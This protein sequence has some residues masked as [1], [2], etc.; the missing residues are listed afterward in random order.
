[1]NGYSNGYTDGNAGQSNGNNGHANGNGAR[2]SNAPGGPERDRG[3]SSLRIAV[4]SPPMLPVPPATYAGTERVVA[5]LVDELHARGHRVTLFAP[6]DSETVAELV[7]TIDR[8]LWSRGYKG[9]VSSYINVTLARISGHAGRFDIIHSHV[10]TLGFLFAR[11]CPTPVVTTLHGR[12]DH[13][14]MPELLDEFRDIPLV[15]ISDSQRRWFPQANWMGTIHHGLPLERLPFSD[16]PGSYLAFVGRVTPEKGVAD[17]IELARRTRLPLRMAAKVYDP[18]EHEYFADVV[19]PAIREG[20]VTFLG[21]LGPTER[22]ALYAG[23]AATLMLGAWPEPFGLVAIE[24]MATGTPIIARRAGAL[25]ETIEHHV[26]GYLVDDLTEAELAVRHVTDLRRDVVRQR[27]M[28][29]FLPSRMVDEYEAVYRRLID[30]PRRDA[31]STWP[32]SV[33]PALVPVTAS[34]T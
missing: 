26:T 20:V 9:N 11:L 4:V 5:A 13:S 14:G 1:M 33:G 3:S 24:S 12:L 30:A 28:E 7:P 6:G 19:E 2:F 8:S 32:A 29:R 27:V 15:A 31:P 34:V 17:A 22:D 16:G 10:E 18:E 23:A 25:T 21:E